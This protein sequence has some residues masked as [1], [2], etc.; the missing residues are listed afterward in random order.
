MIS[1][2][3]IAFEILLVRSFAVATFHH[4]AY[5][6]IGIA[7]LGLAAG[8]TLGVVRGPRDQRGAADWLAGSAAT[9][10]VALLA[11]PLLVQQIALL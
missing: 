9:T 10:I 2:A 8:G 1:A 4:F 7:M 5:L 11:A 3:T 6:A